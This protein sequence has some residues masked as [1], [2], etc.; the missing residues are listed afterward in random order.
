[1]YFALRS[2]RY[3]N[4]C[5]WG[6]MNILYYNQ[7]R[8]EEGNETDDDDDEVCDGYV[9]VLTCCTLKPLKSLYPIRKLH[10]PQGRVGQAWQGKIQDRK[11]KQLPELLLNTDQRTGGRPPVKYFNTFLLMRE[12]PVSQNKILLS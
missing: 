7:N 8:P 4:I 9:D 11:S 6:K 1:M 12:D 3:D 5:Q 2:S 10:L